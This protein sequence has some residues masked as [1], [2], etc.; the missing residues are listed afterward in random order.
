LNRK[1]LAANCG[2][3]FAA[4][5]FERTAP[6]SA[7]MP[8]SRLET[9]MRKSTTL[10]VAIFAGAWFLMIP[11]LLD[12]QQPKELFSTKVDAVDHMA[13]SPN[14][15]TLATCHDGWGIVLWDVATG[16]PSIQ[17]G[18]RPKDTEQAQAVLFSGDGKMLASISG[19]L[20]DVKLWNATTG[21]K[22][23]ELGSVRLASRI[24]SQPLAISPDGKTLAVADE[25]DDKVVLWDIATGKS[26]ATLKLARVGYVTFS[27]DGKTVISADSEG[28][29]K[30]WDSATG[31]NIKTTVI[32]LGKGEKLRSLSGDGK[33]VAVVQ[34]RAVK[35]FDVDGGKCIATLEGPDSK[36]RSYWT[37]A[38]SPDG[39]HV[40]AGEGGPI[41]D[42]DPF[43]KKEIPE[44]RIW[45]VTTGK[46]VA[47][48]C[49]K[50][51]RY[52]WS[53]AFS[54]DGKV[55]ATCHDEPLQR[56][57]RLWDLVPHEK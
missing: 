19:G 50:E 56:T 21:K 52:V 49:V 23:A 17:L 27:P 20:A 2:G 8:H 47:N 10:V 9:A 36:K 24:L 46:T 41:L 51:D 13:F 57:L 53:L 38:I 1:D 54:P 55:L 39:K 28:T 12:A 3:Q 4:K 18:D 48:W 42:L 14:G 43:G 40:A 37:V 35:L 33:T 26:I 6:R 30:L 29:V 31:K 7:Q 44:T 22:V 11:A 15:K 5:V 25:G 34:S 16:K 32:S 45:D